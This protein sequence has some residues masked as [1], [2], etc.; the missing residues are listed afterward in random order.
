M[1]RSLYSAVSGLNVNQKSMDVIGNNI[2]NVNTVGFKQGRAVFQDLM[3]QTLIGGKTPTDSRGGINPRQVGSGA[4]LAAVDNIFEQGVLKSTNRTADLAIEGDGLFIVRGEGELQHYYT[5]A[6]DFNF[7][8]SGTLTNPSGYKV[9]GW[10][11]D[12]VTGVLNADAS[13]GDIVLGPEYKIMQPRASSVVNL[14]GTLDT[15]ATASTVTFNPFLTQATARQPLTS[16]TN[17]SGV[18]LDLVSGEEVNIRTHASRLSLMSELVDK[19]GTEVK[20]VDNQAVTFTFGNTPF[21]IAYSAKGGQ[22]RGDGVF[23]T[24]EE[25]VEEVNNVFKQ[26]GA[27]NP[28][29]NNGPVASIN[30]V[31]GRFRLTANTSF[32]L[33]SITTDSTLQNILSTLIGSYG[34]NA[35]EES[36]DVFF[37]TSVV[38]MEDFDDL[39]GLALQINNSVNGNVVADGFEA[40]FLENN[41][42]MLEGES[43]RFDTI[44]LNENPDGS[45]VNWENIA[46]GPFFYTEVENPIQANHFHTVQELGKLITDAI[47]AEAAATAQAQGWGAPSVVNFGIVGNELTFNLQGGG[48]IRLGTASMAPAPGGTDPNPYLKT[49]FDKAFTVQDISGATVGRTLTD[50]QSYANLEE[51]SGKGRIVYSYNKTNNNLKMNMD[52]GD[53]NMVNGDTLTFVIAGNEYTVTYPAA[54]WAD[55]NAFVQAV[56]QALTGGAPAMN[57]LTLAY[58]AT[59]APDGTGIIT[60]TAQNANVVIDDIK[61][62]STTPDLR[63]FLKSRLKNIELV[64]GGAAVSV[65]AQVPEINKISGLTIEK[66]YQGDIFT[67]NILPVEGEIALNGSITSE[68]FLSVAD[69]TTKM[70]D[71]FTG[72]GESFKFTENESS[73]NFNASIGEELV[74]G[75]NIFQI[76]VNTTY[77]EMAMAIEEYLG[78]GREHNRSDNVVIKDGALI[79]TGEKGVLNNIDFLNIAGAGTSERYGVFNNYMKSDTTG[80][81]GGILATNMAL[82]DEQGNAH[83]VNFTF[84]LWNEEQNEW[85]LQIEADDPT[86][87]I[88]INGAT[89]NE[90]VLK[91]NADGS[92]A[93]MYDR[94]PT[95]AS[96]IVNPTL[97][98]SAA[99]GT[100]TL[101]NIALNL[102][103]QGGTD[104]MVIAAAAGTFTQNSSDGY[105]QGNLEST[106][107]NPAGE[108]VGSYTNGQVRTVGQIALATFVNNQGLTKL[109]DSLY[110]ATGN[111]GQATIGKPQTGSRGDIAAGMLENSNVD[112]STELVDMITTQR[113]F[114]SN[115]KVITTSDEMIQELLGM[116]R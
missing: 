63:D 9:Q 23:N 111:S 93:Y 15:R 26:V 34:P 25:F 39:S 35:T 70:V 16:V 59:G 104:G 83:I 112:L 6:G 65:E 106:L 28:A 49:V 30:L 97:R 85:R 114:Q 73:L 69:E 116:K 22:N 74:T 98:F 108:I 54:G 14:A 58:N 78:L 72:N 55:G 77:G 107:F 44:E 87:S 12:P 29:P 75:N 67:D 80:A 24:V 61:T 99:N 36:A 13:V 48:A 40:K 81:T 27:L 103:S 82:Y 50:T 91:F 53:F 37:E 4:Y 76:D 60:F 5:R 41:F 31:D 46:I 10:M 20:L 90:L 11:S 33:T 47:N 51:I 64:A 68:R 57:N 89:A 19:N 94:F 2:A 105:P 66:G 42:G 79:V 110:G 88:A 52:T 96:I 109:G 92:L 38:A 71:L 32:E 95:P 1:L 56:N 102:G 17:A 84:S 21:S 3:S 43:I 62:T 113:G 100:N 115:S 101:P 7:D 86:N 45:G 8:S 18:A